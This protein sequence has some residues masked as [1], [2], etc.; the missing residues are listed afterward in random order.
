MQQSLSEDAQKG[1]WL[2]YFW[3]FSCLTLYFFEIPLHLF[4]DFQNLTFSFQNCSWNWNQVFQITGS[5]LLVICVGVAYLMLFLGTGEFILEMMVRLDFSLVEVWVWS[6]ALG[7]VFW[8]LLAES[9]AFSG[10]FYPIVLKALSG[11]GLVLLLIKDSRRLASRCWP[12]NRF[13]GFSW[14]WVIAITVLLILTVSNLAAPEMSWDA[15]T[16][17]LVLPRY[18]LIHHSFYPVIGMVPSH[19]PALGEMFFSWGLAWGDDSIARSFCFF[20]HL[21]TALALVAL[22]TRLISERTGWYAAAF[23]FFFPYLNIYSTRGYVDLFE[24]FY[25]TLGLGTLVLIA[26]NRI[27]AENEQQGKSVF[28]LTAVAL[29]AIWAIK[30]NAMAYG[31]AAFFVLAWNFSRTKSKLFYGVLLI[32]FPIFFFIPWALKSWEY[33]HN[34]VYPYLADWFHS[35]EWTEFDQRVSDIKFPSEGL[36]GIIRLPVVLW[37]IFFNRYSGA[38]NEE[39]GLAILVFS[40]L[41]L[42]RGLNKKSVGVIGLAAGI[43]FLFWIVTSHQLRLIT[44][45]I[46]L[47][48]LII[49]LGFDQALQNWKTQVKWLSRLPLILAWVAVFYLFQGLLEQP[50]PFPHFLGLQTRDQ[51][52][53]EVMRPMGYVDL[54][55]YLNKSLPNDAKV[56]ILGQQN[57]YYLKRESVYDFDFT[58]PVLKEGTDRSTSS[59]ELYRWFLK[60]NFSYLLYNSNGMMASAVQAEDLG[61]ERYDWSPSELHN[62]EQFFLKYTQ[63]I[64]IPIANGYS[65]YRVAPRPG[66]STFPDFLPGTEKYYL[67]DMVRSM[68]LKKASNIF[69]VSLQPGIYEKAY[70]SVSKQ[71][72]ELGYPSFQSALA[73]LADGGK[74]GDVLKKV[75]LG[76]DRNGDQASFLALKADI[77]LEKGKTHAAIPFL[78]EA[79][80]F[81]PEKDDVA[82]NLAVAYY[83]EHHLERAVQ[84]AQ[85]AVDLAPSSVDYR[86]LLAQL[87]TLEQNH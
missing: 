54:N 76:L 43:P 12:F 72:P 62:Y 48:S 56:L 6:L 5:H 4:V 51:F 70:D 57:G 69:G 2:F 40:P 67:D 77:L 52:L 64:P 14:P 17:Q 49:A 24:G 21:G 75:K 55:T 59:E 3:F 61:F 10:L 30:Y 37:G 15:I 9:L 87:Q 7:F 19:S 45:V 25:A 60:N 68:G 22:G 27:H 36:K 8:G 33:V 35:F 41:L 65:L 82:R 18:Y 78:E 23:Y 85:R 44:P 26:L 80:L 63:K 71:H 13:Q 47:V 28:L 34:P 38:P 46:A 20:A 29:G 73:E 11:L 66:F 81:S 50:N 74:E 83:N 31:L 39:V 16:Y 84:E 1:I 79:Q 32:F 53:N 42:M 86:K 58:Y